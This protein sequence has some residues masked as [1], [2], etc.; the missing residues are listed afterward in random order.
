MKGF[1]QWLVRIIRPEPIKTKTYY[2]GWKI[3]ITGRNAVLS[4]GDERFYA[5]PRL[6]APA[7]MQFCKR[8][9]DRL[10]RGYE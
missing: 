6:G 7:L 4:K 5:S 1:L 3:E 2:R 8:K 10:S 9:V